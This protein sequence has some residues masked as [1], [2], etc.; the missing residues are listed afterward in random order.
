MREEP[1]VSRAAKTARVTRQAAYW[2]REHDA[3]FAA[4]W[5]KAKTIGYGKLE[6]ALAS[7]AIK[8]WKEPVYHNGEKV[9]SVRKYDHKLGMD[10]LRAHKP[11]VYKN[12]STLDV[13]LPAG[14]TA[15]GVVFEAPRDSEADEGEG[16]DE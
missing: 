14:I 16:D 6:D 13:N 15:R 11:E 8:G 9:G 10:L 3:E 2:Q 12:N 7:R 1:N 5:D 4:A